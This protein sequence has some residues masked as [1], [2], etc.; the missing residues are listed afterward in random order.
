MERAVER[1]AELQDKLASLQDAVAQLKEHITRLAEFDF[2]SGDLDETASSE[3]STEII[4]LIQ[5][6]EEDLELFQEEIVDIRPSKA[7]QHDKERLKDG[8]ERLREELQ[9]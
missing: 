2:P 3:L 9:R 7:I 5:E 6:Q 4:Q 8:A 1:L